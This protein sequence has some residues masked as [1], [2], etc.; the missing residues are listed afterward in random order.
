MFFALS[1]LPW[2]LN[3]VVFAFDVFKLDWCNAGCLQLLEIREILEI[4]WNLKTLLEI[5]EIFLNL[6]CPPGNFCIKCRWS[7]ALVSNHDKIGYRTIGLL[8]SETGRP[9]FYLC[10]G[11]MLCISCFCSIFR[12][13]SRFGTLHSRSKHCKHVLDFS[14]NPSWNLLEISWIF[15]QVNLQTP[16]NVKRLISKHRTW[17]MLLPWG[18]TQSDIGVTDVSD[19]VGKGEGR[20]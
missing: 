15:V 19:V 20:F 16:C 14:W 12:Q 4:Y 3:V 13:T 17:H 18:F 7:T 2:R 9:F 6:S 8:I 11:S 5:L 1:S 10:H